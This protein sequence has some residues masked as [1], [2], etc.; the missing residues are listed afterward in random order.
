MQNTEQDITRA[1][2]NSCG[3][4]TKHL[5]I[6][7]REESESES[8][9]P[10][11]PYHFNEITSRTTYSMLECCGCENI[12]FQ[13]IFEFSEWPEPTVDYYP[14]L[15]SRPLP[16][17]WL[18]HLP[19]EMGDLLLEV[20]I[21]LSSDCR[22]LALMGTRT[23]VDLYMTEKLGDIGGFAQK[24][25][26]LETQGFVSRVNREYLEAA[27][28]I[29]HAAAHRGHEP[30]A[31]EVEHVMDIVENLLQNYVLEHS[32]ATLRATTPPR[33]KPS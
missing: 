5:I 11:D 33:R 1:H 31:S 4:E 6:A 32:A 23:L 27:L 2:C 16:K 28:E 8:A 3:H 9:D 24:L 17:A 19:T 29:G 30:K 21:A 15:T 10:S 26:Q 25:G 14:P 22:R 18:N 13:K 12:S 20:Y 7:R